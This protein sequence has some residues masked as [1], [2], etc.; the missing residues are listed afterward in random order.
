MPFH[1]YLFFGRDCR[2]AFTRYGE[3]FGVDPVLITSAEMPAEEQ[4]PGADPDLIMHAALMLRD[5]LL[6]G[7][8]DP[9]TD[10]P[11]PKTGMMVSFT[12]A[13]AA[14]AE[15]V[16]GQLAEGGDVSLPLSATSWS[17]MFG[18][19]TDRFGVP[20]MVG[21]DAPADAG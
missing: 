11:G 16:F 10:A 20:W 12:A 2:A 4:M 14:E 9:T 15:R 18:M 1:P 19:C 7:S 3:I 8:D 17:P 5:G 6:M 21:V 13:D